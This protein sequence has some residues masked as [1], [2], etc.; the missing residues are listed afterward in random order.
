MYRR[1]LATGPPLNGRDEYLEKALGEKK[2]FYRD[3]PEIRVY[4]VFSYMREAGRRMGYP[5]ITRENIL[6]LP[7]S[8][9]SEL[10]RQALQLILGDMEMCGE[11][12]HIVSTP[13]VFHIRPHGDTT[14]TIEEAIDP[15]FLQLLDPDLILVFIDNLIDVYRRQ[16]SDE[17]WRQRLP[18]FTLA[19]A[20]MWRE[21]SISN[22]NYV[23]RRLLSE[24]GKMVEVIQFSVHHPPSVLLDLIYAYKPRVYLSYNMTGMPPES[25]RNVERFYRKLRRHFT[26]MDPGTIK[27]WELIDE[28]EEAV[29]KGAE[30]IRV[31]GEEIRISEVRGI[32]EAIDMARA[33]L[34]S[35]DLNLVKTSHAV[36]VYHHG[37]YPSY[38]VMA[39]VMT[40]SSLGIPV[41]V[42]YPYK[43]R[44]SPFFEHYVATSFGIANR[45][46]SPRYYPGKEGEELEDL[47]VER[48]LMDACRGAWVRVRPEKLFTEK[49]CRGPGAG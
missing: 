30:T 42:Y 21:A 6:D 8:L 16:R 34:V 12:I 47:V 26:V 2:A 32:A 46:F 44:P 22:I 17:V 5:N 10:R 24:K 4:S 27:D 7:V 3:M 18:G 45:L 19:T 36:A 20:A 23:T 37:R 39:E 29:E 41:Y 25:F 40:A 13:N 1:I 35:R 31:G 38:G 33:Q 15:V 9:L 14:Y 48:M 11:C 28:Y 49:H 43:K